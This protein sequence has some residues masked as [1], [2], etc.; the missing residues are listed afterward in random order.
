MFDF[1]PVDYFYHIHYNILLFVVIFTLIHNYVLDIDDE[2]NILYL[3]SMGTILFVFLLLFY[4]LRPVHS[5]FVDMGAYAAKYDRYLL[6]SEIITTYD[7]TFDYF[8]KFCSFFMNRSMFFFVCASIYIFPLLIV[9][10]RIFKEYWFYSFLILVGSF[11]FLAYGVN[12]IRNGMA[13][14]LFLLALSY[15]NNKILLIVF[16]VLSVL[17]HKTML[18][19]LGAFIVT[20]FYNN[21]KFLFS[22]FCKF[23][24]FR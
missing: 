1:I 3:E 9:S 13:T 12:G 14:S 16:L 21:W 17:F 20:L 11:S 7:V 8:M 4:G 2:K 6:G 22:N 24:I 18:L 10:K 19:P 5:S 15:K 23:G